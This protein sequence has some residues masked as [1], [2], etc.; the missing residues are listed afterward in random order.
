MS[1]SVSRLI[2][3]PEFIVKHE[4]PVG[5]VNGVN[6]LFQTSQKYI[7]NT[8]EVFQDGKR[9]D[10]EDYTTDAENKEFTLIVSSNRYRQNSP[11]CN[12]KIS[13]NYI[14]DCG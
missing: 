5:D 6:V 12:E 3:R 2:F 1:G 13:V 8:L 10:T 14:V 9:L 11:P 7:P 4:V